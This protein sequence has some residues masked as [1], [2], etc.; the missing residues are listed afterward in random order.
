MD[1]KNVGWLVVARCEDDV[2]LFHCVTSG[3]H[4][5]EA[6]KSAW[7]EWTKT[8]EGEAYVEQNGTNWGDSVEIPN[9]VLR[10]HG[11]VLYDNAEQFY[12]VAGET[13]RGMHVSY[14]KKIVV[15]HD[16][17]LCEPE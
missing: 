2:Y 17:W 9:E 15:D 3:V 6:L 11:I 4:P 14:S 12:S 1:K 7:D 16:E 8:P 13:I 5:R 10:R